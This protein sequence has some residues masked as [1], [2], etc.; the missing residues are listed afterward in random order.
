M[1]FTFASM[2]FTP[3]LIGVPLRLDLD[4]SARKIAKPPGRENREEREL[5][6]GEKVV[7][8]LILEG[9]ENRGKAAELENLENE[10]PPDHDFEKRPKIRFAPKSG[11][12]F[13]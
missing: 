6:L 1:L 12:I 2:L 4:F 9:A 8:R 13:F 7:K 5:W 11:N 10:F 3:A